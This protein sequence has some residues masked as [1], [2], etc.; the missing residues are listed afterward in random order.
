MGG[1]AEILKSLVEV[2]GMNVPILPRSCIS[3][4]LV[5]PHKTVPSNLGNSAAS[6][7]PIVSDTLVA[8]LITLSDCDRIMGDWLQLAE[9]AVEPNPYYGP[10]YL[11]A[12]ARYLAAENECRIVLVWDLR[13]SRELVGF[14]PLA[15]K[16]LRQGFAHPVCDLWRDCVTGVNVPLISGDAVETIWTCFLKFVAR[17]PK[18]PDI[19]HGREICPDGPCGLALRNVMNANEAVGIAESRHER[20]IA[21]P[22]SRY[23][24]Y[25]KRWSKKRLRNVKAGLRK[26][27]KV[28]DITFEAVTPDD[29]DYRQ[30]LDDLLELEAAGWKGRQGTALSSKPNS[31][32]FAHN[33]LN[34]T[35]VP[36]ASLLT[37]MRLDGRVVAGMFN[38]VSH[39]RIHGL[40]SGYDESLSSYSLGIIMY[41]WLLERMLD[42]GDYHELDSCSDANH[43][44]E[45]YWLERKTIEAVFITAEMGTGAARIRRMISLRTAARKLRAFCGGFVPHVLQKG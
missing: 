2:R 8:E 1:H 21:K 13:I 14:F 26:L 28:G 38:L 5:S 20:S 35:G 41:A 31:R 11:L 42:F 33:A 37:L 45:K 15:V 22:V 30:A 16:G 23:D 39:G 27:R 9:R 7:A 24:D 6:R 32:K 36:S 12:S 40:R 17:H 34:S 44:L 10:A 3:Q 18:L 25:T 29:P 19:V 43:L 4:S